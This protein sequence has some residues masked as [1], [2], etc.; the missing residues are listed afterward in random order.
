M[1]TWAPTER[2]EA[3]FTK[4]FPYVLGNEEAELLVGSREPFRFAPDVWLEQA[5]R[6]AEAYLGAARTREVQRSSLPC[7]PRGKAAASA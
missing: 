2:I 1:C 6:A 5:V 3:T 4:V 7:A